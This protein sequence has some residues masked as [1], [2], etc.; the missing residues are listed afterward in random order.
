MRIRT[1]LKMV[2]R[3]WWWFFR[4]V[5]TANYRKICA[6]C[7]RTGQVHYDIKGCIRFKER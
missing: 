7:G 1:K 3:N 2:L 6:R 5:D 4:G